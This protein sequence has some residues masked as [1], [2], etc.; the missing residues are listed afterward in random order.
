[1]VNLAVGSVSS[2]GNADRGCLSVGVPNSLL[3]SIGIRLLREM[4]PGANAFGSGMISCWI[5]KLGLASEM[6]WSS[7]SSG[8]GSSI[9]FCYGT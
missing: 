3:I 4:W 9:S 1:M 5:A 7:G 2:T 6:A 8:V